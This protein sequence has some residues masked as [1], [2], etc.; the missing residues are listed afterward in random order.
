MAENAVS[1]IPTV[2]D[3]AEQ[4]AAVRAHMDSDDEFRLH[5]EEGHPSGNPIQLG[6]RLPDADTWTKRQV[7]GAQDAQQ[8][9]FDNTTRPKKNFKEEAMKDAAGARFNNSMQEV[10]RD[11]RWQGGMSL[12]DE[13]EAIRTIEAGGPGIYAQGV[14]RREG[15]IK[16]RVEDTRGDRLAICSLVDAM[17]TS[18]DAEREAKMIT[19]KRSLQAMGKKRR[20][21]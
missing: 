21:G 14:A 4:I 2:D 5:L 20:G 7:K 3:L 11:N 10:I 12:V 17:P 1:T 19:N 8:K 13:G 6:P 15:K 16:K 18:T 9:W